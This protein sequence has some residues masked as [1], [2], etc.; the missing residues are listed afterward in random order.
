MKNL[1]R[2]RTAYRLIELFTGFPTVRFY[3]AEIARLTN[4]NP[5]NVMRELVKLKKIGIISQTVSS[6]KK[7]YRLNKLHSNTAQLITLFKSFKQNSIEIRF[8]EN[9]ILGED[10]PNMDPFIAQVF[11]DC[12]VSSL[13]KFALNYQKIACIHH[14]YHLWFYITEDDAKRVAQ[15]IVEEFA[16]NVRFMTTVNTRI[17]ETSDALRAYS[18]M[19]PEENLEKLANLELLEIFNTHDRL[20]TE[21][22]QWGWIPPAS[23]MFTNTLTEYGKSVLRRYGVN[24]A[25]VNDYLMT[26]TH[27]TEPSLMKIEQD[28]FREIGVMIQKDPHELQIFRELLRKFQEEDVKEFGL[29][30]HSPEYEA[31][32]E[33]RVRNLVGHIKSEILTALQNHYIKYFYTKFI[34]TEEQ[35]VYSFEHYLKELVRLVSHT[36]NLEDVKVQEQDSLITLRTE[37]E[38]LIKELKLQSSDRVLFGE[39]GRFMITK[40]YRRYAQIYAFYKMT[41][42][43]EEIGRRI[44]LTLKQTRFMTKEEV[45]TALKGKK[46]N[47]D[48]I[49]GRGLFSVYYSTE[50]EHAFFVGAEAEAARKL[51]QREQI[52]YQSEIKGQCGC[53]GVAKG[54]V[55]IVNIIED[56][57]KMQ[58]GDILVAISTQPDLLPAMKKAAAF[59]TDQGG[60]TCH[61]AIVAREM[62]TPCVIGTKIATKV[63]HDGDIVEVDA[64]RGL[65][66]IVKRGQ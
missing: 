17:I 41:A 52:E 1:F 6:G 10:I 29:Y 31:K 20:H 30:T 55:R 5:A 26:L 14:D 38:R 28:E 63:L 54:K 62:N 56:M 13:K 44:G 64:N 59:V 21:Y 66:T 65:V 39:W 61:A 51:I 48:H 34:F 49:I 11:I 42:I 53:R 3:L 57:K 2:S 36:E 43:L 58:E 18:E 33:E 19:I 35:G 45:R 60:V 12:I 15:V 4:S 40:I 23:D 37:R 9:W 24:E 8:K 22:Y 25:K 47:I 16:K 27:P 7:Y 46:I 50:N 32:F